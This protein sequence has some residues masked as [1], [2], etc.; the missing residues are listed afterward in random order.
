M[1]TLLSEY[2]N[3]SISELPLAGNCYWKS[4]HYFGDDGVPYRIELQIHWGENLKIYFQSYDRESSSWNDLLVFEYAFSEP[5]H[6]CSPLLSF[7]SGSGSGSY[8]SSCSFPTSNLT[9]TVNNNKCCKCGNEC[10]ETLDNTDAECTS[11]INLCNENQGSSCNSSSSNVVLDCCNK[12]GSCCFY[13]EATFSV[14]WSFSATITEGSSLE[15]VPTSGSFT[16]DTL[17]MMSVAYGITSPAC[18]VLVINDIRTLATGTWVDGET[19]VGTTAKSIFSFDGVNFQIELRVIKNADQSTLG[20]ITINADELMCCGGNQTGISLT[21]ASGTGVLNVSVNNNKCCKCETDNECTKTSDD[22]P[23]QCVD[24][25]NICAEEQSGNCP[26]NCCTVEYTGIKY[27][28]D[29]NGYMSFNNKPILDYTGSDPDALKA[30]EWYENL[31]LSNIPHDV[32]CGVYSF[33]IITTYEGLAVNLQINIYFTEYFGAGVF[34]YDLY[35]SWTGGYITIGGGPGFLTNLCSEIYFDSH[36]IS[37][38]SLYYYDEETEIF[39]NYLENIYGAATYITAHDNKCRITIC[40]ECSCTSED[41]CGEDYETPTDCECESAATEHTISKTVDG[42]GL[43]K[44]PDFTV[45]CG[46]RYCIKRVSGTYWT[47]AGC[48][49]NSIVGWW[50]QFYFAHPGGQSNIGTGSQLTVVPPY[51]AESTS[52]EQD[53]GYLCFYADPAGLGCDLGDPLTVYFGAPAAVGCGFGSPIPPNPGSTDWKMS[54]CEVLANPC[55][56]DAP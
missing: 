54:I 13:S 8:S 36:Y 17:T 1:T 32:G 30:I 9:L 10:T 49:T 37:D 56:E 47:G 7:V 31:D 51:D 20:S 2:S 27:C 12:I 11:S 18:G 46:K 3:L 6:C 40:G 50:N 35:L 29:Q 52:D 14:S 24:G 21:G 23:A 42:G 33:T 4:N 41:T 28:F 5:V 26:G 15:I 39:Y 34:F 22:S 43:Y 44:S 19:L 16:T 53:T 48:H 55:E 45:E 38:H 25:I